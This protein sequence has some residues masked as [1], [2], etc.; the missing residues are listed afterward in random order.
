MDPDYEANEEKYK[1]LS[2][3]LLGSD[4]DSDSDGSGSG[5]SDSSD[6]DDDEGGDDDQKTTQIIAHKFI[7]C[8]L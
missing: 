6:D 1:S 3:E 5:S 4:A 7:K 8:A 2:K